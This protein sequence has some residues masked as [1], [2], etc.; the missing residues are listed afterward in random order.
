[1]QLGRASLTAVCSSLLLV[2][3]S[4][5][6]THAQSI[7]EGKLTGTVFSEDRLALPGA[8]VEISSP[9]L[10]TATRSTTSSAKGSYVFLNLRPGRYKLTAS[11]GG[12]KTVSHDNI[13]IAPGAAATLDLTLPVGAIQETVVVSG[14]EHCPKV[15]PR[16]AQ[17][18]T[19]CAAEQMRGLV[20]SNRSV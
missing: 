18:G 10:I 14:G 7:Q 5:R 16:T 20:R 11:M 2:G 3:V 13:D 1:M 15:R 8:T 19:S 17:D 4:V 9:A 6:S 12:F